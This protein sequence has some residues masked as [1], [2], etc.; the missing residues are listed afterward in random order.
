MDLLKEL[1]GFVV[2]TGPLFLL[3]MWLP[4]AIWLANKFVGRLKHRAAKIATGIIIFSLLF[5]LP[6][7]DEII[8]K[9]YLKHLCATEMSAEVFQIVE[10]PTEYWDESGKATFIN[11]RGVLDA[12]IFDKQLRWK[13]VSEPYIDGFIV[14]D[15]K[16]QQLVNNKAGVV[17]GEQV[18]FVLHPGWLSQF[19]P[20]PSPSRSCPYMTVEAKTNYL[21]KIFKSTTLIR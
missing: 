18:S 9:I 14:I 6:F 10:L 3:L 7:V 12:P 20:G 4:I 8:G 2:L 11:A 13:W 19:S 1:L 17:L 21:L 15:K 16:R 5:L